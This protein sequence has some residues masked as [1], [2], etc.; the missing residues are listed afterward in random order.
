MQFGP[1]T[2]VITPS[3]G[4]PGITVSIAASGITIWTS[5]TPLTPMADT[6]PFAINSGSNTS[7]GTFQAQFSPDGSAGNLFSIE[8]GGAPWVWNWNGQSGKYVGFISSWSTA[9]VA[10]VK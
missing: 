2:V 6:Q 9:A 4:S 5:T 8:S 3:T 7:S 10:G 1:F